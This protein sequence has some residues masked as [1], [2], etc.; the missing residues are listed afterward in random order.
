MVSSAEGGHACDQ[1]ADAGDCEDR[2]CWVRLD[3]ASAIVVGTR[4]SCLNSLGWLMGLE[5]TTTGI[6]IVWE[7]L[8]EIVHCVL[9]L[10]YD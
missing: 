9:L 2:L 3:G 6:T 10:E 1:C 8:E 4:D 5:P 7:A